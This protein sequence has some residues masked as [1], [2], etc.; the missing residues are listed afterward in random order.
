MSAAKPTF[1]EQLAGASVLVVGCGVSGVS[2]ARFACECGARVRVIDTRDEPPGAAALTAVCPQASLIVGEFQAAVLD[3]IDHIVVSPG[4]DLREPL[5]ADARGRGLSIVGDVEWFARVVDAPVIAITGSNGKSTVTAWVG[6]LLGAAGL[7]TAVGGNFGTPAL[8]L[9]A[10]GIDC[11]VLELSSFQLEL[12]ERLDLQAAVV[13]N[14]SPDHIDRHGDMDRYAKLKARIYAHARIALVNADDA[15]VVA[16]PTHDAE[17]RRFGTAADVDYR[18]LDSARGTALARGE[19]PWLSCDA[20]RLAGRHNYFNAL[21]VWGLADALGVDEAAI[22]HGLRAF[23]GLPHRCQTVADWHGVRWINDSKGTNLGALLASLAGMTAPVILLAGGQAKGADF[24]PLGPV[25]ADKARAVIVFGVD[26]ELI[27]SAVADHVEVHR[28]TTLREAV[29]A[30]AAMAQ[31]GDTV[32]LSPGCASLDQFDNYAARGDAF[33][34]AV[35]EL[36]A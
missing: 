28:V 12:V 18:L 4:V 32:L 23:G 27:A 33:V 3:G 34:A 15:R 13:L 17:V 35:Q 24:T 8:D 31:P 6:E 7:N 1:R 30:A 36:A 5:I 19:Q 20:L 14:L 2:A 26:A 16:M 25:A 10:E 22:G 21:A 29:A 11:Y 9:L